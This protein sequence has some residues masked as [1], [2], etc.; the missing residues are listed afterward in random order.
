MAME[1]EMESEVP[2]WVTEAIAHG[3][4]PIK[5]DYI[6]KRDGEAAEEHAAGEGGE[7]GRDHYYFSTVGSRSGR[8]YTK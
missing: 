3:D 7:G 1:A 4:V 6:V 5:Q 8:Q 2:Q